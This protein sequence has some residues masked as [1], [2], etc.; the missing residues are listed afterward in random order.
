MKR[1]KKKPVVHTC[2]FAFNT[3]KTRA[4][5]TIYKSMFLGCVQPGPRLWNRRHTSTLPHLR[6]GSCCCSRDRR[7]CPQTRRRK[8]LRKCQRS[9]GP[10]NAILSLT[11]GLI[12]GHF[13]KNSNSEKL[14]TRAKSQKNSNQISKKLKIRQLH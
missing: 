7:M 10:N 13:E 11:S 1:A 14:K 8:H 5:K 4:D 12:F 3:E 6:A 2:L 9:G